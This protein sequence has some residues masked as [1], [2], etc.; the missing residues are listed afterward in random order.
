M[1]AARMKPMYEKEAA[2]RQRA[3]LKQNSSLP[4]APTVTDG[5]GR[6]RTRDIVG[7]MVGVSRGTVIRASKVLKNGVD[8]LV[9][10]VD[11]GN[12][13]VR[14]AAFISEK[15]KSEQPTALEM[16]KNPLL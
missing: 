3:A 10:A 8:E 12:V 14:A 13:S 1:I 15:P 2:E 6:T 7:A 9:A 5:K 4:S 16:W 11:S